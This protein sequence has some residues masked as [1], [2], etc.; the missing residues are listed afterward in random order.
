MILL[1]TFSQDWIFPFPRSSIK[2]VFSCQKHQGLRKTAFLLWTYYTVCVR[3]R[4]FLTG[5][6]APFWEADP[7]EPHLSPGRWCEAGWELVP[8]LFSSVSG[9]RWWWE[10][11]TTASFSILLC[12][13]FQSISPNCPQ[14]VRTGAQQVPHFF[15]LFL[16]CLLLW[17]RPILVATPRIFIVSCRTFHR[18][19]RT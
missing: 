15:I 4:I 2:I 11:H 5:S 3:L 6:S 16:I 1:N 12:M 7:A 14:V 17:L 13:F 18:G 19:A 8:P 10:D 9:V